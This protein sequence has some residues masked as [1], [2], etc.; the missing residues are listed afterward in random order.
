MGYRS[1]VRVHIY[2]TEVHSASVN[3]ADD[4]ARLKLL[5]NTTFK[6][7]YETWEG[8]F[9][10]HDKRFMLDFLCTDVKWYHGYK[11]IDMFESLLTEIA[12]C[13]FQ[14]EFVRVGEESNDIERRSS[15]DSIYYLEVSRQIISHLE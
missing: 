14:Y 1:D 8:D 9:T 15:A 4:Y 12:E 6:E 5:M 3:A 11:E 10:W 7:V 2:P 13:G